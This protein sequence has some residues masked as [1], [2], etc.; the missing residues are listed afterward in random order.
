MIHQKKNRGHRMSNIVKSRQSYSNGHLSYH[1]SFYYLARASMHDVARKFASA[2]RMRRNQGA[3]ETISVNV[4]NKMPAASLLF[5]VLI[6][7]LIIK[8][9][10]SSLVIGLKKVLFSTNSLAKL[11]SDSVLLDSFLL[12]SLLLDSLLSVSSISQSHSKL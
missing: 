2:V 3:L 9:T 11:L 10:I 8:I 5:K 4:L 1:C 6:A 7:L 12:D